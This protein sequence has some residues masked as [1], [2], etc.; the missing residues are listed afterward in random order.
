MFSGNQNQREVPGTSWQVQETHSSGVLTQAPRNEKP[1]SNEQLG[2]CSAHRQQH[3]GRLEIRTGK[4]AE[5]GPGDRAGTSHGSDPYG[6][7]L[8]SQEES[9]REHAMPDK[10]STQVAIVSETEADDLE[11]ERQQCRECKRE[12]MYS[13]GLVER[14]KTQV[15]LKYQCSFCDKAFKKKS[16]LT[17]HLISHSDE[18]PF[19]CQ[20]CEKCYKQ[21][22]S[23][24]RHLKIHRRAEE[25]E[26]SPG[27]SGPGQDTSQ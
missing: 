16:N 22:S 12:F 19:L 17:S 11:Q 4:I 2:L 13:L 10:L 21:K 24:Q 26:Q 23:L 9:T 20:H 25:H 18:R 5:E 3:N 27:F 1:F 15:V 6:R 8:V 14:E 7:Q